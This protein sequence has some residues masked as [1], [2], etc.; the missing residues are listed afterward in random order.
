MLI[1]KSTTATII[2]IIIKRINRAS[3]RASARAAGLPRKSGV[4]LCWGGI[5]RSATGRGLPRVQ[6]DI[7][8]FGQRS[9]RSG[10]CVCV[11]V[12]VVARRRGAGGGGDGFVVVVGGGG[13]GVVVV[14]ARKAREI[15]L[16]GPVEVVAGLL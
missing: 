3:G 10:V 14:V 7:E 16:E 6:R 5:L 15:G 2:T 13:G 9:R 11:Y 8:R 12:G 4:D 1:H